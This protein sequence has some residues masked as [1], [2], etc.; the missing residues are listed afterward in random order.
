M[1][2]TRRSLVV[3]TGAAAAGLVGAGALVE[4]DVLPGRP[5]AHELLGLNGDPGHIPD[6]T[7]GRRVVGTLPSDHVDTDPGFVLCYPPGARPGDRLPAVVLLHGAHSSA[8]GKVDS[9]GLDRF[10]AASGHR[11]VL[12]AVDGG[13]HSY[14]H[15]RSDGQDTGAMVLDDFIPF[16]RDHHLEPGAFW[17]WS[18]GGFGALALSATPTGRELGGALAVSPALWPSWDEVPSDAFDTREQYDAG[19]ALVRGTR[20]WTR[21]DCGTGDPFY[22]NDLEVLEHLDVETHWSPGAHD[23]GYWTRVAPGQLDWLAARVLPA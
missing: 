6:V 12:A 7:P 8:V 20:P 5:L 13:D 19:M 3:G 2:V 16:L 17:G 14:W 18:M 15:E 11:M 22:R 23:T 21:V 10:L 1:H 4:H 9:M